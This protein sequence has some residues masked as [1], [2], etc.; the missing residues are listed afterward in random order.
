LESIVLTID[1][2]HVTC[3]PGSSI[4]EA[5]E[6]IGINIPNLC[7]HPDL[8]PFGACRLCLVED[9]VTGRLAASCVTPA[10][11]GMN[12]LTDTPRLKKHRRNIVR[13]M[14]AEHPE[15]CIVC[16]K[17]N[18]CE[19][20]AIAARLGIGETNLYRLPNPKALEQANPFIVRDLSKCVLCGKCIRADHELVAVGAIDYNL[21][22]FRSRPATLHETGLEKS[23]C[24]FCGT[25]VSMCPTGALSPKSFRTAGS[26]AREFDSVCGFCAVGCRLRLGV[27]F[28]RVIE[29]NPAKERQSVNRATLCVRGHFAHDFLNSPQRL[30]SPLQRAN[31]DRK[32]DEL[33]ATD[34]DTALLS[35]A[36]R[37]MAIKQ[38]NGPQSIAFMGSSKG[39]NEENF[40]FQ[41]IA[42][43]LIGTNNIDNGGSL[44]SRR[45]PA[46]ADARTAGR[47]RSKPL[48]DLA[49]A[50]LIFVLGADPTHSLPVVGYALK[51]AAR[52]GI[53]LIVAD[54]RRTELAGWATIWLQL[55]PGTDLEM[56]NGLAAELHQ[57]G[58]YDS[59]FIDRHTSGFSVYRYSL[60]AIESTAIARATGLSL[61]R[62]AATAD[63]IKGRKVAFVIGSGILQQQGR[64]T[65]DALLN[66]ALLTGSLGSQGTG[67]VLLAKENNQVGAYD[68]GCVPDALPGRQPLRRQMLRKRWEHIWRASLSPDAG[69]SLERMVEEAEKGTLKAIYI[70]AENPLR[71]LPQQDRVRQAFDKLDLIVAQDILS[72]ETTAIAD[73]VLPGAAFAEKGG[74]FT[75]FE[76]RIQTFQPAVSPPGLSKPDWQILARLAKEMGDRE[77]YDSIETLQAEIRR[78]VPSYAELGQPAAWIK[79]ADPASDPAADNSSGRIPFSAV[80]STVGS[81][82]GEE[83]PFTAI[84]GSRRYHMG[85]GTRTGVSQRIR[86]LA[87]GADVEISTTDAGELGLEDG[88]AVTLTSRMGLIQR[89]VSRSTNLRPGQVFVPLA[90]GGN[91][92]INLVELGE[93]GRPEDHGTK[94]CAVKIE[95]L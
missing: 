62:L 61:E 67:L 33:T 4:L 89:S 30:V 41:K 46:L 76:G 26:P 32:S 81:E 56:I 44:H 64:Y 54:P 58:A 8:K 78:T 15:S 71:S 20:R 18:R 73:I 88:D 50:D 6:K 57:Q 72:N 77:S 47:W 94:T 66:L 37:M 1:G 84:L 86:S 5:A 52:S 90:V 70:F 68:M 31:G 59:T 21:R 75:N 11:A 69:L 85:S 25:C 38:E 51:R 43:V 35:V 22:G 24:T 92:G 28:G 82:T 63:L 48:A 23:S 53:P 13:L 29:V 3:P 10:V 74:S 16:T 95:K 34:W 9:A 93:T 79:D 7:H 55:N 45:L 65:I 12:V 60:S 83:Y 87:Q 40:L 27:G 17:G 80:V 49:A 39:S 42:R 36:E 91:S 19:L 2:K 14:I